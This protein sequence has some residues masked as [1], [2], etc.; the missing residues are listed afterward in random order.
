MTTTI[1]RTKKGKRINLAEFAAKRIADNFGPLGSPAW[2]A[3]KSEIV[4]GQKARGITNADFEGMSLDD[5]RAL[6][7]IEEG[8]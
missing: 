8:E 4:A 3:K 2:I 6:A 5:I 7:R 1:P